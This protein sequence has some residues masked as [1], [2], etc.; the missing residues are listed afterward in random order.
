MV[1]KMIRRILLTTVLAGLLLPVCAQDL[2]LGSFLMSFKS[3]QTDINDVPLLW[4]V[5]QNSKGMR[6]MMEF[7]DEMLQ[8]GVSKRVIYD[9]A[10]SSWTMLLSMNNIKQGTRVKRAKLFRN[11]KNNHSLIIKQTADHKIIEGYDCRKI[12]AQSNNY[13]AEIWLTKELN[14]DLCHIYKLLSHCGMVSEFMR[15][16]EWFFWQGAKGMILEVTSRRTGSDEYYTLN[17]SMIK[18]YKVDDKIFSTNGFKISEIPEGQNCG[19]A[20]EE[21]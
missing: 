17:I 14:F 9:P 16:G 11:E 13:V 12:I 19:V 20:V 18:Q 7:Q 21:K 4:Y 3:Q 2:F 1:I 10:D 5:E 15:K 8:R 6:M